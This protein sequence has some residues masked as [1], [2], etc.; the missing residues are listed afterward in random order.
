MDF[1]KL[2][3]DSYEQK[4]KALKEMK[5]TIELELSY[6]PGQLEKESE[7]LT[8]RIHVLVRKGEEARADGNLE[9]AGKI[10]GQIRQIRQDLEDKKAEHAA[11]QNALNTGLQD[12]NRRIEAASKQVLDEFYPEIRQHCHKTFEELCNTLDE[13]WNALKYY[14]AGS[15]H[16]ESLMPADHEPNRVL[17][18][19]LRS[20]G[21]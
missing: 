21:F 3:H 1:E 16:K 19:R 11:K 17:F 18:R 7:I 13:A 15:Q 12:V 10:D 5:A 14:G 9:K 6:L 4:T 8:A 20:W 2:L